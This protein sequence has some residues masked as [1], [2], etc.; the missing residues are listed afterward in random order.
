M[1]VIL[2]Q[3]VK[4]QGKRGQMVNVS[5]G[6]ARNFLLPRKLA[7]EATADALNA[8]KIHDAAVQKQQ[9]KERAEAQAL[10]AK[11]KE[12]TVKVYSKAGSGGRLFG[13]ITASEIAQALAEQHGVQIDKRKIQ[14]D[15]PIKQ[16]GS[17]Q[18]GAKLG[19]EVSATL[20][21][22]VAEA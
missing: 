21:V 14:L 16:F 6:Y 7:V 5:D 13:S 15:A 12:C 19:Y 3:D 8:M 22:V 9:E 17:Y 2:Q 4:G 1:K 11:L 18:V 20:Y 10:A